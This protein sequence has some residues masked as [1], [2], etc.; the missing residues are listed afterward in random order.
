MSWKLGKVVDVKD[1][2]LSISFLGGEGNGK[3]RRLHTLERSIRDVSIIF[4]AD[5]YM[6][7]TVDHFKE[8]CKT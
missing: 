3:N 7:N 4:S 2:K 5:E 1:R 8:V 6:I